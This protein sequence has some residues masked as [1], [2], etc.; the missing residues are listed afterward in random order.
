[1]PYQKGYVVDF[2]T[3]KGK[4]YTIVPLL[5]DETITINNK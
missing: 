1:L 4:T 2:A 3:V 5:N